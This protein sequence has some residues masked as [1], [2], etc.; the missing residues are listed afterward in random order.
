MAAAHSTIDETAPRGRRRP[1]RIDSLRMRLVA[2]LAAALMPAAAYSMLLALA[3]YRAD[4]EDLRAALTRSAERAAAHGENLFTSTE[5]LLA[6]IV[7]DPDLRAIEGPGCDMA[8]T[9]LVDR[10]DAYATAFIVDGGGAVTCSSAALPAGMAMGETDWF[11]DVAGGAV[12]AVS[13]IDYDPVDGEPVVIMASPIRPSTA[14]TVIDGTPALAVSVKLDWLDRVPFRTALTPGGR[15]FLV[16]PDGTSVEALSGSGDSQPESLPPPSVLSRALAPGPERRTLFQSTGIDGGARVYATAAVGATNLHAVFTVPTSTA[17]NWVQR[18]LVTR[19][20]GPILM[21]LIALLVA[22]FGSD[23]LVARWVGK[24]RRTAGSYRRGDFSQ[25]AEIPDA[26]A[27]LRELG[28]AFTAMAAEIEAREQD[29]KASVVEKETL[30][31]EIHHRVKNNLQIVTSLLNLQ[32]RGLASDPAREALM[33]TQTRIGALALVHRS[34]Y[35]SDNVQYVDLASFL[36]GLCQQLQHGCGVSPARVQLIVDVPSINVAIEK[37][38]PLALVVTEAVTNA[39]KHAFPNDRSG[40]VA[41]RLTDVTWEPGGDPGEVE[42]EISDNGVGY[43]PAPGEPGEKRRPK[44]LGRTLLQGFARQ[45]G[46]QAITD[47]GDTEG[48]GTTVSIRF[49]PSWARDPG[50]SS[51]ERD[52][53]TREAAE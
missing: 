47:H 29:L 24:L 22:W 8:L 4:R 13:K 3:A 2:L 32:A 49:R 18:D 21:W 36:G 14:A 5:R 46:G 17:L 26:P 7:H 33:A 35:E 53:A 50:V 1:P 34:L 25:T 12:M 44:G 19:A 52:K 27:E 28:S 37:A 40:A 23:R 6:G 20:I 31:K 10:F 51:A 16:D 41:V 45:L 30:L 11:A 15:A 48:D 42:L 38:I 43:R 39:F 9:R